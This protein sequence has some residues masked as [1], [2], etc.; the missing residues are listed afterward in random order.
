MK[1]T[2]I[3][4]LFRAQHGSIHRGQARQLGLTRTEIQTRLRTGEWIAVHPGVYCPV[5]SPPTFEQRVMSACLASGVDAV[6][7]HA[8]AAWLWG[9][10]TR[11]PER[12]SLTVPPQARPRLTGVDVHRLGDLDPSRTICRRGI[13]CTDP[14]RTLVDLAAVAHPATTS[15]AVD[16]AL[17]SGLVSGQGLAAEIGRRSGRGRRGIRPLRTMLTQRGFVGAP[18]ASVLERETLQLLQRWGIPVLGREVSAGPDDRYR[19]DFL[20]TPP[21]A[22]EVDGYSY[23]W[24]PEAKARDEGRRN[25]LRIEG[26]FLLVYTSTWVDVRSDQ[27][28]MRDEISTALARYAAS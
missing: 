23:H 14:L 5:V 8:S 16:R 4:S 7:S 6:A 9:L 21:V 2:H 15:G 26:T 3:V 11:P 12:V 28:R 10:L 19:L 17:A 25:R 24:S 27:R 13:P 22:M 18:D 1:D 20:L